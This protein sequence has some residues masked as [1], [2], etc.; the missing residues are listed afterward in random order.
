MAS[1]LRMTGFMELKESLTRFPY[2]TRALAAPILA[3]YAAQTID[4]LKAAYPVV[5]GALRDG[6]ALVP[7]VGRGIAA[8]VTV[9]SA[10]DHA[11]LYEFGTVHAPPH[12]TFLPISGRMRRAAVYA[13]AAMVHEQGILVTGVHD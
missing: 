1:E 3:T 9:T 12:P 10:S 6:V 5:T 4:A 7:R 13:I 2:E 11:H 8:V